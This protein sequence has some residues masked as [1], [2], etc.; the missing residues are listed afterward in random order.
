M[1]S[2]AL[3]PIDAA[4][5]F[6]PLLDE[7]LSTLRGLEPRDWERQTVAGAWRVRDVAAHVLDVDLRKVAAYRDDHDVAAGATIANDRDLARLVNGMNAD[8]V[9]FAARLS[10]RLIV[11][12]L[13]VAG[14][15]AVDVIEGLAPSGKARFPVSW[16]GESESQNWMDTGRDYTERWHHQAQIRDASNR[17]G[18]LEPRWMETLLEFSVR[19]LPLAYAGVRAP[20]S[21]AVTLSVA[22]ETSGQW[23]IVRGDDRWEV[24]R[25]ASATPA[26]IVHAS[27]DDAW[28]LFYNALSP[29]GLATRVVVEGDAALAGPLLRARSVIL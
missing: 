11:D 23:S 19:S 8:G 14:T 4:P 12:L 10:P 2:S 7:L 21:T 3:P 20:R 29:A 15:W 17:P 24:V 9:A 26:A 5:L 1:T 27:T 13:E 22:G 18:L 25:G 16:A 28:R 6:R